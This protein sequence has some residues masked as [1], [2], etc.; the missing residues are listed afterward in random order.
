MGLMALACL[1]ATQSGYLKVLL[2]AETSSYFE[3]QGTRA[4]PD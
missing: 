3:G 4:L 1:L 2:G